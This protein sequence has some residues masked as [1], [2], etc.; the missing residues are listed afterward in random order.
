MS[1]FPHF[2]TFSLPFHPVLRTPWLPLMMSFCIFFSILGRKTKRCLFFSPNLRWHVFMVPIK[3]LYPALWV[4]SKALFSSPTLRV[5]SVGWR[6][7]RPISSVSLRKSPET[8]T[9]SYLA[10]ACF[11]AYLGL[12]IPFFPLYLWFFSFPLSAQRHSKL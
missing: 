7:R 2:H 1:I 3:S 5:F 10:R 11:L 4:L 8:I 6:T 9:L 12:P